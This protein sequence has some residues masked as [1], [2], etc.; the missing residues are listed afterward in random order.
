MSPSAAPKIISL[1]HLATHFS[2]CL[3]V[4][5]CVSL[6]SDCRADLTAY[7]EN[8]EGLD[9]N[10]PDA[11]SN[12]GWLVF[13]NVFDS[14]G[15]FLY[16]YGPNGAP[17]GTGAFSA[18]ATG[19]GGAS[20]GANVLNT[21][22]DYNNTD[23]TNFP[24]RII[25]SNIF[26]EQTIGTANLGQTWRITFDNKASTNFGP[27]PPST[28]FA[29]FKVLDSVGGSFALIGFESFE[30]TNIPDTWGGGSIDILID[31]SWDG[32]L[33]QLGFLNTSSNFSPTGVF[34]DNINFNVVPEPG[35]FGL[36]AAGALG[37]IAFRR[38]K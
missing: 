16:G 14:G 11:L 1:L 29:F 28:A 24:T 10:D 36:L 33:F 4:A 13:G 21:F 37:L 27:A 2:L 17:N 18:V 31:Q 26:R 9:P 23:H 30:T 3:F 32:Q 20:Q 35:T 19:E 5:I 8:F 34:Y 7:S 22:N 12:T 15:G 6:P 38:R 25:E